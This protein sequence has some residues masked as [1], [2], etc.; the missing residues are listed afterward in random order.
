ML[1][2]TRTHRIRVSNRMA[3]LA[4]LLLLIA[5]TAGINSPMNNAGDAATSVV[6]NSQAP[7][8]AA[9]VSPVRSVKASKGFKASLYLFRRN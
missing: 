4:T 7:E 2:L 5:A 8:K 9:K 6:S 3:V 1:R